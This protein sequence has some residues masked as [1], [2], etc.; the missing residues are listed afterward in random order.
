MK[1]SSLRLGLAVA[2]SAAGLAAGA[3]S[4]GATGA[5]AP[6]GGAPATAVGYRISVGPGGALVRTRSEAPVT[7][8][9]DVAL[10][11]KPAAPGSRATTAAKLAPTLAAALT[12]P[13][14]S[15]T[16]R[17]VVGFRSDM[18]IPQFPAEDP[19]QSRTSPANK[20][21]QARAN[22]LIGSIASARRAGY[23]AISADLGKLGVT[24]VDTFWLIRAMV[25]DAPLSALPGIAQRAD[26]T[27]IEPVNAGTPARLPAVRAAAA[28]PTMAAARAFM[29]T[30][31]FFNLGQTS[32]YIGV[33]SS[34]VRA[35]HVL[36]NNPSKPWFTE[37]L[38][39]PTNPDPTDC[40][41]GTPLIGTIT[42][43]AN[44]GDGL[45]GVTGLTTDSFKVQTTAP[46]IGCVGDSTPA[47]VSGFQ[48]AVQV[49]DRVILADVWEPGTE[50][51]VLA[52]AADAAFDAG[53]VVVAPMGDVDPDFTP[54][55]PPQSPAVAQ[56]VLGV[57]ELDLAAPTAISPNQDR[58]PAPD[59][60]TKPDVQ[61]PMNVTC[62]SNASDSATTGCFFSIQSAAEIT[63]AAALARN[64]LRGNSTELNPGLV[65]AYLIARGAGG[66]A[67]NNVIGAG[68][69]KLPNPAR[70]TSWTSQ[71]SVANRQSIDIPLPFP[72]T[73]RT[74]TPINIAIWWPEAPAAHNDIDVAL[75]DPNGA[76]FSQSI[77]ASGVFE[78]LSVPGLRTPGTWKIR[79]T[80]FNVPAGP[81]L[82]DIAATQ[83]L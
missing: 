80:G 72:P 16:Q 56:K 35:T 40:F 11:A 22:T 29:G 79:V 69:V 10:A 68:P 78:K 12:D 54:L 23:Q 50:T 59:G 21:V 33:L 57:G 48:R 77:T 47:V 75:I 81:Q 14:A 41:D 9:D 34:G 53:A 2:L 64:M 45:R 65:Y 82:V 61:G 55:Q 36:F 28:T 71:V 38:A 52:Q 83:D 6:A 70:S 76:V 13:A 3:Q 60:R 73:S 44:L 62:A 24:T 74:D 51:G 66:T 58:G 8:T 32:G 5:R 26:V 27:S 1:R 42:G 18:K 7:V 67:S 25:V 31:P 17:V 63:G 19:A 43:N 4:V 39:N 15:K 20:A 30:D 49:G 46:G 37:D